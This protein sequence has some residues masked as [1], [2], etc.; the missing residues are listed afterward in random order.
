MS[1]ERWL[2]WLVAALLAAAGA[3]W[4]Q[5]TEWHDTTTHA[6]LRGEAASNRW[7]SVQQLARQLGAKVQVRRELNELPPSGASLLLTS[8]HWDLFPGR[9]R[10]LRRWVEGG[11]HLVLTSGQLVRFDRNEQPAQDDALQSWI[12]VRNDN[13]K[14]DD[15]RVA[16]QR[17]A[18]TRASNPAR[19]G[20]S[21]PPVDDDEDGAVLVAPGR[22]TFCRDY[23][24]APELSGAYGASR[25]YSVCYHSG[26][27]LRT[28]AT[29]R[30]S[31]HS[32][33]GPYA[34]NLAIGA[35][36]VSVLA[37]DAPLL[38]R[39]LLD[40]D[41]A[42]ITAAL[43]QLHPGRLVWVV[44][45]ERRPALLAWL[46]QHGSVAL[47]LS[48]LAL[49]LLLWR[50][51]L[52]FGPLQAPRPLARRAV[53]EQVRGTA[54]FLA[55]RG[56]LALRSAQQRALA[57]TAAARLPDFAA[58]DADAQ[59]QALAHHTG[60][61]ARALAAAWQADATSRA[62]HLVA[63]L[64]C[65]ETARRRLTGAPA[66]AAAG[67]S[68]AGSAPGSAPGSAAESSARPL[69]SSVSPSPSSPSQDTPH[70][71]RP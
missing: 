6:P 50:R 12:P 60:L 35:G 48:L 19:R 24:E 20:A 22:K 13:D 59:V 28:T 2:P 32:P 31:V 8:R 18:Q 1:T 61:D 37:D 10:A 25:S 63:D 3:W 71:D 45:D 23:A 69:T 64:Q 53:T 29:P 16:A 36:S 57:E 9:D 27:F 46:W 34:M 65:L 30:W 54:A 5:A 55:Q 42:L 39:L 15:E 52:R 41:H 26:T 38:N 43:L 49:A 44:E 68:K 11:G 70:A 14:Q 51:A 56:G 4:W 67:G 21:A 40:G 33:A 7:Y 66:S 47:G 62:G 58:L 17:R